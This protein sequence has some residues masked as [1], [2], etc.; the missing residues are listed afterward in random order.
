MS[1]I[2]IFYDL[3]E[4]WVGISCS[5]YLQVKGGIVIFFSNKLFHALELKH[6]IHVT[7]I[8]D[9]IEMLDSIAIVTIF[10]EPGTVLC[11]QNEVI[12][13][14]ILMKWLKTLKV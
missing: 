12:A 4:E 8:S 11:L 1:K 14:I 13:F 5:V 6:F 9:H 7:C 3:R 10:E 2:Y